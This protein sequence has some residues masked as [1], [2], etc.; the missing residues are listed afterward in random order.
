MIMRKEYDLKKLNVKR[1][2]LLPELQDETG[3]LAKVGITISLDHDIV[4]YF[5]QSAGGSGALPYQTQINQVSRKP[6][7]KTN[8]MMLQ[9]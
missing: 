7:E 5:K 6:I 1:R 8:K 3:K 2:G 4:E 9:P